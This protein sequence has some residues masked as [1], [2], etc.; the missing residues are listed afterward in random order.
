MVRSAAQAPGSDDLGM[1]LRKHAGT[2]CRIPDLASWHDVSSSDFIHHDH[3]FDR[4]YYDYDDYD[5]TTIA[6]SFGF[7]TLGQG[8]PSTYFMRGILRGTS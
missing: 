5:I 1:G 6:V 3:Y 2:G 8:H 4:N 7:L